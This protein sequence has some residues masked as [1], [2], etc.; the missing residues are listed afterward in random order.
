MPDQNAGAFTQTMLEQTSAK[1][2]E[3][4]D[5]NIIIFGI[6]ESTGKDRLKDFKALLNNARA[7]IYLERLG[8]I[9]EKKTNRPS[10]PCTNRASQS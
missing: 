4:R 8:E 5:N 1:T 10:Q 6:P 3:F 2:V 9:N 7:S